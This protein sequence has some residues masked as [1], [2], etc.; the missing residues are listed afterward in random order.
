M[1]DEEKIQEA[2]NLA[3]IY[4]NCDGSHHKMWVIDQMVRILSGKDYPKF[5]KNFEEEAGDEWPTGMAP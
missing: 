3:H 1:S 2:L 5:K 4:G